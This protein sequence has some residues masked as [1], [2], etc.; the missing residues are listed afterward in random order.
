[1]FRTKKNQIY[2]KMWEFVF[3]YSSNFI[4]FNFIYPKKNEFFK[5]STENEVKNPKKLNNGEKIP[6]VN[7]VVKN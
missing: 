4:S 3:L 5:L 2:K 7:Y 1:M 6:S